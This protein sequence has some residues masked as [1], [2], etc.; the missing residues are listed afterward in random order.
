[1]KPDI[2]DDDDDALGSKN[3]VVINTRLRVLII[4]QTY[5]GGDYARIPSSRGAPYLSSR[6]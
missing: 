3:K 1:V 2:D 6:L 4:L 5:R